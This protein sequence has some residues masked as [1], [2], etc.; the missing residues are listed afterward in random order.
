M[1]ISKRMCVNCNRNVQKTHADT[2]AA[3]CT[4]HKT[5]DHLLDSDA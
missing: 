2:N 4:Y 1:S 3:V 5:K